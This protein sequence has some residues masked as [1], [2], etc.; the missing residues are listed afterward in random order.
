MKDRYLNSV[1]WGKGVFNRP[2]SHMV[3][4]CKLII[5]F[6][7]YHLFRYLDV[8]LSISGYEIWVLTHS[9][10]GILCRKG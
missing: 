1:F 7:D 4:L 9:P 6:T 3:I 8:L 10:E 5:E 2:I